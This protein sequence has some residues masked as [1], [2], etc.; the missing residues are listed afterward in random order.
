MRNHIPHKSSIA[1]S[2]AFDDLKK[3]KERNVINV[4]NNQNVY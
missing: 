2:N 4:T 3:K 1:Y